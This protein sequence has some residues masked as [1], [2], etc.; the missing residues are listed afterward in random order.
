M[1]FIEWRK[2]MKIYSPEEC[3]QW[4]GYSKYYDSPIKRYLFNPIEENGRKNYI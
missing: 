2:R 3:E 1:P 4:I